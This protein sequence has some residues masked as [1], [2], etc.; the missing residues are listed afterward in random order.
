[1]WRYAFWCNA[2]PV[3]FF[4]CGITHYKTILLT[5]KSNYLENK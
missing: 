4:K 1:M 3:A 5:T 2:V